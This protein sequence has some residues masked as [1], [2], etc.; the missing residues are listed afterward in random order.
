MFENRAGVAWCFSAINLIN[1][2]NSDNLY[3][4]GRKHT[5]SS[6]R[7]GCRVEIIKDKGRD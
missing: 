7:L 1:Y 3:G 6:K 4:T 2:L 5:R